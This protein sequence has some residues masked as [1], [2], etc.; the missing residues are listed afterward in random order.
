MREL[1]YF[2]IAMYQPLEA[3]HNLIFNQLK[4]M[5]RKISVLIL[6]IIPF[7]GFCQLEIIPT[8]G[9]DGTTIQ[10]TNSDNHLWRIW[11][12]RNNYWGH[13][14]TLDF[15]SNDGYICMQI[16]PDHHVNVN[17]LLWVDYD[18]KIFHAQEAT[19]R[20]A[21]NFDFNPYSREGLIME[22]GS[23]E[24][25]GLY[26]DG[27]FAAIW[28]PG[29]QNRLLRVY[30]EDGMVEKWYLDGSGYAHTLSDINA[31][32]NVRSIAS[33]GHSVIKNSGR[34]V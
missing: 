16:Y 7:I 13:S 4:M 3:S 34:T 30:D 22:Q 1:A 5:K 15:V 11:N 8:P 20:G 19:L 27:D 32:E 31:K 9:N 33:G 10:L 23:S 17:S 28:S 29:D 25:S 24:G 18:I 26:A 2:Y 21:A 12:D 14:N 6:C